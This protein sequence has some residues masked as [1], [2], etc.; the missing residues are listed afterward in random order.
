[1]NE[2]H[3]PNV[4]PFENC[5]DTTTLESESRETE[6]ICY[7]PGCPVCGPKLSH[8]QIELMNIDRERFG[9]ESA[10]EEAGAS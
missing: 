5:G 10:G 1:M 4:E 7:R 8:E 9:L 2:R 6:L 3:E